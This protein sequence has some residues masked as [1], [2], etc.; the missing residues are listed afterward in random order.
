L[1]GIQTIEKMS[2]LSADLLSAYWSSIE[3][4]TNFV[5]FMN[6]FGALLPGLLVD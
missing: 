3:V 6:I 1:E 4:A 2:I 5:V